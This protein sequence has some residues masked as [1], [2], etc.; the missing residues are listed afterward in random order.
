MATSSVL[1]QPETAVWYEEDDQGRKCPRY[2]CDIHA[3]L[4]KRGYARFLSASRRTET[5]R[6]RSWRL[7]QKHNYERVFSRLLNELTP[8][9][10]AVA[11]PVTV[12]DRFR[13][14]ADEWAREVASVS[15][16]TAMTSHPKYQEIVKLGWDAVP[17]MLSDLQA[18][19]GYWFTALHQITGI[20]PFDPTEAGNTRRMAEAWVSWG[21]K[22]KIEF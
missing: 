4:A 19:K 9:E 22:K 21:K 15:S 8:R 1:L 11:D 14:L 10:V 3:T 20:R 7:D 16:V 2:K 5:P 12:A 18:R 13:Q 6:Y 17:L